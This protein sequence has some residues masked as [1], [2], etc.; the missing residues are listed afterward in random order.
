MTLSVERQVKDTIR[1]FRLLTKRD[2][3]LVAVSGGKVQSPISAKQYGAMAQE[4][5]L[6]RTIP[7]LF[8][9]LAMHADKHFNFIGHQQFPAF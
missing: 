9:S 1:R 5:E 6:M 8:P 3:I 4:E 7:D 2:K